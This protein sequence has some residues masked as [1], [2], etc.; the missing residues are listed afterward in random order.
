MRRI[1]LLAAMAVGISLCATAWAQE[2][3]FRGFVQK[4]DPVDLTI[5]LRMAGNTRVFP[6][7]PSAVIMLGGQVTKLDQ[8]PLNSP[9]QMVAVRDAQ[10][11]PR[12]SRIEIEGQGTGHSAVA[13]PGALI[14]GTVLGIDR[15]ENS[16]SVR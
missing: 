8:I 2:L 1:P 9:V 14:R 6:I 16:I 15:M 13:P 12:A 10:G 3:I 5:T 11:Q 7:N 4:V